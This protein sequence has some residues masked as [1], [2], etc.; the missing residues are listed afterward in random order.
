MTLG[1][2]LIVILKAVTA[3]LLWTAFALLLMAH[4]NNPQDFFSHLIRTLFRGNPPG[5]A[6]RYIAQNTEFISRT[7]LLRVA[8]GTA[9][10][11]LIESVEAIGLLLRKPWAEWLVILVTVSFIP[12]ELFELVMRP[13]PLKGGT[14]AANLV[15]LWYLTRRLLDKRAE[16]RRAILHQ[17]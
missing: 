8:L 6:I 14:L 5:L 15:I 13:A 16:H 2:W 17:S 4:A 9:L 3:A 7:V 12:L 10:Y 1:L 11:A